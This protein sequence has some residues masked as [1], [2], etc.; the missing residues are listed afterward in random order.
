MKNQIMMQNE[1]SVRPFMVL[2]K[3][4]LGNDRLM[5]HLTNIG[6][7]PAFNITI[8]ELEIIDSQTGNKLDVGF[9]GQDLID[10]KHS[11]TASGVD[12]LDWRLA[13]ASPREHDFTIRYLDL[14][15]KRYFTKGS[16]GNNKIL[17]TGTG[18][19]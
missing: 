11:V 14:N 6:S 15:N 10:G 13:V 5:I 7:G 3:N 16:L 9:S 12:Q 1:L 17:F 18:S 19:V 2:E 4:R 8:D